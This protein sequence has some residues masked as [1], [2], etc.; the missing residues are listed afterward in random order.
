MPTTPKIEGWGTPPSA[1]D[2]VSCSTLITSSS[3]GERSSAERRVDAVRQKV[4]WARSKRR[5]WS[6]ASLTGRVKSISRTRRGRRVGAAAFAGTSPSLAAATSSAICSGVRTS[7]IRASSRGREDL[8]PGGARLV[9]RD[10]P[11]RHVHADRAAL[12]AAGRSCAH[13][14]AEA[15]ELGTGGLLVATADVE[16]VRGAEREHAGAADEHGLQPRPGCPDRRQLA[17]RAREPPGRRTCP[18]GHRR[19]R[20]R[21]AA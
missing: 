7:V 11:V 2:H 6:G 1:A 9:D 20:S 16:A 17:R 14:D 10:E 8:D 12:L 21:T 15:P 5:C 13:G 19:R 4:S 3:N 18:P